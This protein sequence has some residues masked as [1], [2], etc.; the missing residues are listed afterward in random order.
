M[1]PGW[2]NAKRDGHLLTE[3][4]T[5]LGTVTLSGG[6]A[7]LATNK[8]AIGLDAITATYNGSNSFVRSAS[9]LT[10]TV[11]QD[12]TTTVLASSLNPSKSGQVVTFT[13]TVTAVGPGSGT[14]TGV[15]T[16]YNGQTAI[17]TGTLSGGKATVKT[18]ALPTGSDAI[19]ATYAGDTN[20]VTSIS[21]VVTQTVN[22]ISASSLGATSLAVDTVLGALWG[23]DSAGGSLIDR[24]A[25]EQVSA[26]RRLLRGTVD[27]GGM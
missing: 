5:A 26:K 2:G 21:A 27:R 9:G 16:F 11:N 22:S 25:S 4:T 1:H 12:A 23:D 20:F 19:T 7:S 8:L 6:A 13:A 15:V 24:L 10:Q 18:N 3:G 17:G 14:P